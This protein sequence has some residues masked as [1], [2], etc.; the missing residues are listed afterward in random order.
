MQNLPLEVLRSI[1]RL[2]PPKVF[3]SVIP[4]LSRHIQSAA[5]GAIPGCPGDTVGIACEVMISS[6]QPMP[7]IMEL[8]SAVESWKQATTRRTGTVWTAVSALIVITPEVMVACE[9][10]ERLIEETMMEM[11]PPPPSE[12]AKFSGL[13]TRLRNSVPVCAS[14][15]L[16]DN[17]ETA[18]VSVRKLVDFVRE[19]QIPQF[20]LDG[21]VDYQ[22]LDALTAE[23]TMDSV[24]CVKTPYYSSFETSTA[25]SELRTVLTRFP[26]VTALYG[27]AVYPILEALA[28]PGPKSSILEESIALALRSRVGSLVLEVQMHHATD[29][30]SALSGISAMSATGALF[31]SPKVFPNLRELGI[32]YPLRELCNLQTVTERLDLVLGLSKLQDYPLGGIR[33]LHI[34]LPISWAFVGHRPAMD[35]PQPSDFAVLAQKLLGILPSLQQL[36]VKFD[37][38]IFHLGLDA[39]K[40]RAV[41]FS[42]FYVNASGLHALV[43]HFVTALVDQAPPRCAIHFSAF[44]ESTA[45][46]REEVAREC[47]KEHWPRAM[48]RWNGSWTLTV[49]GGRVAPCGY[50]GLA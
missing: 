22:I 19:K 49:V 28:K 31:Q 5:M 38:T 32:V 37:S 26:S 27:N 41:K 44:A 46:R 10:F 33:T 36:V 34:H 9:D 40:E 13:R 8:S 43:T 48:R 24:T 39:P 11:M 17:D 1:F 14:I 18:K 50:S 20:K 30:N 15:S 7:G 47:A 2:L 3:Y 45:K 23:T 29:P 6:R 21:D 35:L 4:R 12:R 42:P 16:K 25:A